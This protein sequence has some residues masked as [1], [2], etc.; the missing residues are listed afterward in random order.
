VEGTGLGLSLS[1]G[2]AQAMG[3]TLGVESIVD[4][5]S[6]F[7]IELP[8]AAP[9][10]CCVARI[11]PIE[12]STDSG[13]ESSGTV[14]YIE[15]NASNVRLMERILQQRQGI[16]LLHAAEGRQGFELAKDRRP[17][18]ILLDMHLPD[19]SG[20]DV[21]RWL[22]ECADTRHIP[23]FVLTADATP[24]LVRRLIAA[25]ATQC[26]TKPLEIR[27]V[28]RAIDERLHRASAQVARTPRTDVRRASAQ[29]CAAR[30]DL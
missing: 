26:F 1:R 16:A 11:D 22:W 17:D 15:D 7:W 6:V 30:S 21:I 13:C 8:E 3:G 10:A 29:V 5:G 12:R 2:L 9:D 27:Q 18:L 19:A 25:G 23:I 28:L 4:E 20:E 14:L 24:G